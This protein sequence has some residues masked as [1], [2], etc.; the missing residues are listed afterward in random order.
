MPKDFRVSDDR[1]T[2]GLSFTPGGAVVTVIKEDGTRLH[3]DKIKNP[4]A[5]IRKMSSD[6]EIV[7]ILVDGVSRWVRKNSI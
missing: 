2:N 6:L 1:R 4:E 3:Y 5:Y 7:E